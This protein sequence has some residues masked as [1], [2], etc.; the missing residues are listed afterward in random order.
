MSV[1]LFIQ[2][3][4]RERNR[5]RNK[6]TDRERQREKDRDREKHPEV[7]ALP[8]EKLKNT[9]NF[10]GKPLK[11]EAPPR[12]ILATSLRHRAIA[13][14]HSDTDRQLYRQIGRETGRQADRQTDSDR[15]IGS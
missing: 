10:R 14:R 6:E 2:Q 5:E 8:L 9:T 15:H 7:N 1:C 3:R 13:G 12:I 4:N 11:S